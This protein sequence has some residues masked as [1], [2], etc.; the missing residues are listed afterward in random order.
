MLNLI[1]FDWIG[2]D[3][4]GLDWIG[5]DWIW[6]DLIWFDLIWF[7]LIWFDLI[8]FDLIWFDLK[9]Q[10][11]AFTIFQAAFN[12]KSKFNL[13][14]NFEVKGLTNVI[15][16]HIGTLVVIKPNLIWKSINYQYFL[17]NKYF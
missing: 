8:W 11:L 17:F 15:F 16:S 4:I 2:L 10:I 5:L 3:W 6:F 1:W 13:K 9:N 7:D 14:L 12:L